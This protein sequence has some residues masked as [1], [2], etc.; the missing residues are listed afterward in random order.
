MYRI[1]VS[2]KGINH[3][4][5]N[6]KYIY[7][8]LHIYI[9]H[10]HIVIGANFCDFHIIVTNRTSAYW[11]FL[12]LI[13]FYWFL[14]V[15]IN[16]H[17]ILIA[18]QHIRTG[19]PCRP[20]YIVLHRIAILLHP[21]S[22]CSVLINSHISSYRIVLIMSWCRTNTEKGF[23]T[24]YSPPIRMRCNFSRF[25]LIRKTIRIGGTDALTFCFMSFTIVTVYNKNLDCFTHNGSHLEVN[26][27]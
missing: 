17:C 16:S 19:S 13:G 7:I 11:I 6:D 12:I 5:L 3:S 22:S 18:S 20:Y 24:K 1:S 26:Y 4:I 2:D 15:P 10:D 27:G 21:I 14:S 8:Y 9:S 25:V 23:L